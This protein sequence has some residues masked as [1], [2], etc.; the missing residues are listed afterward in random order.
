VPEVPLPKEL[1]QLPPKKIVALT[2]KPN[3]LNAIRTERLKALGLASNASYASMERIYMELEY[4]EGVIKKLG[5]PVID[6]TNKAVEETASR[7]LEIYNKG[8]R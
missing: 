7:I 3:L 2:I 4:A 6:V 5:C 1:M 8:E